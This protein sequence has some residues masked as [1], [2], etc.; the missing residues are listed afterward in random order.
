[1]QLNLFIDGRQHPLFV[2][3][4]LI[5]DSEEFF[6]KMDEDMSKGWQVGREWIDLPTLE[7]YCQVVADRMVTAFEHDN[8]AMYS[9]MAAYLLSRKPGLVSVMVPTDGE[10]LETEFICE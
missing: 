3:D 2:D 7:N 6:L 1:M 8:K 5:S 9:M 4:Q 10:I